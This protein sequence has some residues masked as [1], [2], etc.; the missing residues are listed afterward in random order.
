MSTHD[1]SS[2]RVQLAAW[3]LLAGL[4]G[5]AAVLRLPAAVLGCV[6][7]LAVG[8]A[9]WLVRGLLDPPLPPARGPRTWDCFDA[10]NDAIFVHDLATGRILDVNQR[11]LEIYG[12]TRAEVAS[13]DVAA[14]SEGVPPHSQAEAQAWIGKA[15]AGLP[16]VFDWRARNKAGELFW[17]EVNMRRATLDGVDRLLVIT[18]DIQNRR[19][20]EAELRERDELF[21]LLFERTGDGNLIMEGDT[22]RDCNEVAVRLIGASSKAELLGAHPWDLSPTLQPD[23]SRSRD[24]ADE[25]IARTFREG[26]HR[27]EWTHLRKDGTLLPVEVM[28]TAIPWRGRQVLHTTWRDLRERRMAEEQHQ[29]LEAQFRQAQKLES[30]GVLAGGIAHDFNNL[31]TA[32]LANLNLAQLRLDP[33]SQAITFMDSAEK[34][35]LKASALTQQM[36]A[37]S[38]KGRF[39]IKRHDLNG[40]VRE[41][42][43]LLD[44]SLPKKATLRLELAEGLPSFQADGAQVQQVIMNLVTNASDALEDRVGTITIE[45]GLERL[46]EA[47]LQ[48]QFPTQALEPGWFLT[49]GVADTGCGMAPPVLARIFDPF[50]T[51]KDKG[52]GLG[53]SAMQGII[54][55]HHAGLR[56]RSAPGAG[57]QFKVYFP[58]VAGEA[59]QEAEGAPAR[60]GVLHGTVLLVDDEEAIREALAATLEAMGF[61]V[62]LARDGLEA[63]ETFEAEP[64]VD[65]VLM[66]LTMPRMDGREAFQAM[67]KLRPDLK[68][69]LSSGYNQQEAVLDFSTGGP[70]GFLQ[71]PYTI[72]TLRKTVQDVLGPL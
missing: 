10:V 27:F 62:L 39:L 42:T 8:F 9:A 65:L 17:V 26:S 34:A 7:A 67:R 23:G 15:A 35:V 48:A 54:R 45:T 59:S 64:G 11:M 66:D 53:L 4:A 49:L 25:L 58:T 69:I 70:A 44:V 19:T 28:L 68:V 56:I 12:Y 63:L 37:Y 33:G 41:M 55:S 61:R 72:Q 47:V 51:T 60:E 50:F 20:A 46:E 3:V 18:R 30:L 21:R 22:Y 43:H 2:L 1:R 16:Q 36:L 6:A 24:K 38:G 40:L 57:S 31:L 29:S 14:L 13:L 5:L 32:I 52:R 71:K